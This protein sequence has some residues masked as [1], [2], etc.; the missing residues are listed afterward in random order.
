MKVSAVLLVAA[1][2]VAGC[3]STGIDVVTT[4][5]F[6]PQEVAYIN[7]SGSNTI[8]G[9]AFMRQRAGGVVTCAG[10][11]V[12]LVPAGKYARQRITQIY[13]SE[14]GGFTSLYRGPNA[15]GDPEYVAMV[16][17]ATC[18]ANGNFR[19]NGVANGQ[20]YVIA[21]VMWQVTEYSFE[22]GNLSRLINARGGSQEVLLAP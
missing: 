6:D 8:T 11:T 7:R 22:G 16:R 2:T 9:Q 3:V 10:S 20:Y 15:E 18:D 14:Q 1:I 19:F 5:P 12:D 17:Q 21:Q 13:G 4:V